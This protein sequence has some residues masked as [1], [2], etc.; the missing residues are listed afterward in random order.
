V[1]KVRQRGIAQSTL[2]SFGA[3]LSHA[4]QIVKFIFLFSLL[5]VRQAAMYNIYIYIVR[6]TAPQ[7][8]D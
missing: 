5:Y 2:T 3:A 6:R 4:A 7:A 1:D 8:T